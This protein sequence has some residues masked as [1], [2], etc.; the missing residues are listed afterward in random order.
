[1]S[2]DPNDLRSTP[3]RVAQPKTDH[4]WRRSS[5]LCRGF[6]R[7][8]SFWIIWEHKKKKKLRTPS[9]RKKVYLWDCSLVDWKTVSRERIFRASYNG[10]T[11][12]PL[13]PSKPSPISAFR[14]IS[15]LDF[16][17][18][19]MKAL[20]DV[21]RASESRV[22]IIGVSQRVSPLSFGTIESDAALSPPTTIG[23]RRGSRTA[24]RWGASGDVVSSARKRYIK[25]GIGEGG[26]GGSVGTI[27]K[28]QI[29]DGRDFR[30]RE[31]TAADP[32]TRV[33]APRQRPCHERVLTVDRRRREKLR[34][35][36]AASTSFQRF[37][38]E[39]RTFPRRP[40]S[41][42]TDDLYFFSPRP[43][44]GCCR[45]LI[46]KRY[47]DRRNAGIA[48]KISSDSRDQI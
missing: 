35:R 20:D 39:R 44:D 16:R 8:L 30:N 7:R 38:G 26:G 46:S 14:E 34:A 2:I 1:M 27:R 6:V 23:S 42:T 32:K 10:K 4:F 43:K 13:R 21:P 22:R 33:A 41:P 17:N 24:V 48:A 25:N 31:R 19:V 5:L 37:R 15:Q 45:S 28:E 11:H 3:R 47:G 18:C 40:V 29:V 36:T 12:G 9:Q